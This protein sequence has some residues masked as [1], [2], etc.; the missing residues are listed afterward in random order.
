MRAK[1]WLEERG[2]E[3]TEHFLDDPEKRAKF[4]EE[5]PGAKTVP[6]IFVTTEV[7][8]TDTTMRVGGFDDLSRPHPLFES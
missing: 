6:Q 8:G 4:K 7:D 2:Y 5:W 3:Y 1:H